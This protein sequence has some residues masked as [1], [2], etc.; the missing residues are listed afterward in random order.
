MGLRVEERQIGEHVYRVRQLKFSEGRALLP[1]L[2]RLVGPAI[3]ALIDNQGAQEARGVLSSL[4]NVRKAILEFCEGMQGS[5]LDLVSDSLAK[6]SWIVDAAKHGLATTGKGS[7]QGCA[8]LFDVQEEHWPPRWNESARWLAFAIEVNFISFLGD[9]QSI[10][11]ALQG[12]AKAQSASPSPTASTG[13][14]GGS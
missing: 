8:R 7:E 3:A 9:R 13:E 5:D 10:A 6:S 12:L 1:A 14:S 4:A 11:D 2:L